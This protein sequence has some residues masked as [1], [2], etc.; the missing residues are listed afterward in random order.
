MRKDGLQLRTK[1]QFIAAPV[2]IQGLDAH[3]VARQDE[4]LLSRRP[5]RYGKHAV[6]SLEAA[7][8]PSQE[9]LQHYFCVTAGS[10][11]VAGV[12]QFVSQFTV[13]VDL[14]VENDDRLAVFAEQRLLAGLQ[15]DDLQ[16]HRSQG[17]VRGFVCALLVRT[18]MNER[19]RR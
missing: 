11:D 3:A 18:P 1:N 17:N 2:D 6:E 12:F 19:V 9:G 15:I 8:A 13:I 4:P 5:Q 16:A 14:A 10:E 7:S